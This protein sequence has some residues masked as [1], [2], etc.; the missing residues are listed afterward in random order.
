MKKRDTRAERIRK[1]QRV[2]ATK[3]PK[4]TEVLRGTVRRRYVRCGKPGCRCQTGRG[5]G[6]VY[7]LSVTLDSGRTQQITLAAEDYEL[8]CRYVRNYKRFLQILDQIS[9][10]NRDLLQQQRVSR[11]ESASAS[12]RGAPGGRRRKG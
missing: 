6:P 11:Q 1:R 4:P 2:A 7:Y 5:H 9:T 3:L 8:A 10:A 12:R